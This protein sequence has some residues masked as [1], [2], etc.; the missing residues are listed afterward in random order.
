MEGERELRD[1][2]R[3][4]EADGCRRDVHGCGGEPLP[5]AEADGLTDGDGVLDHEGEAEGGSEEG[6][7]GGDGDEEAAVEA[8]DGGVGEDDVDLED[9]G[10]FEAGDQEEGEDD[11][12]DGGAVLRG[13][14]V[15]VVAGE[16]V[17]EFVEGACEEDALADGAD[18]VEEEG[19][20]VEDE[21]G[22]GAFVWTG[23]EE[24]TDE[25]E[26]GGA[27]LRSVVDADADAVVDVVI[28][29]G[30]GDWDWSLVCREKRDVLGVRIEV[31]SVHYAVQCHLCS[32]G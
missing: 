28:N 4:E 22:R 7:E 25:K 30:D 32:V 13:G 8:A 17:V 19:E 31:R 2:H 21:D 9:Q 12:G 11:A 15:A 3:A 26:D 6:D 16:E 23:E 29:V 14:D 1:E 10:G 27:D 5:G 24:E 20:S 18:G